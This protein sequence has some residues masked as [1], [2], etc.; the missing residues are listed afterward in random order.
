MQSI[1]KENDRRKMEVAQQ[2][3]TI[4][5]RINS[6]YCGDDERNDLMHKLEQFEKNLKDQIS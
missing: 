2:R 5:N 1:D 3:E 6:P 4:E